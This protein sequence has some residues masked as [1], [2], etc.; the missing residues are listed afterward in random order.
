MQDEN[1][2]L[3]NNHFSRSSGGNFLLPIQ[4]CNTCSVENEGLKAII[5][6]LCLSYGDLKTQN[7]HSIS[8]N[9]F[10]WRFFFFSKYQH[11]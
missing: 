6:H 11:G 8:L 1:G 10:Q 2:K 9:I 5:V 7:P 3:L 4:I